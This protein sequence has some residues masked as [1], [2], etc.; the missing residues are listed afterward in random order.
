MTSAGVLEPEP[1]VFPSRP[2]LLIS[3]WERGPKRNWIFRAGSR[4]RTSPG[5]QSD[6]E[7]AAWQEGLGLLYSA[8]G[9]PCQRL[10]PGLLVNLEGTEL[11]AGAGEPLS[12]GPGA[13]G[14]QIPAGG[15]RG[16]KKCTEVT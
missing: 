16:E 9:S 15:R 14:T 10:G 2:W 13:N 5:G 11:R 8:P 7:A 3:Y 6:K 1:Q 12:W 4:S